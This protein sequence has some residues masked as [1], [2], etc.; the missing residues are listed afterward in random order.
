ML[1]AWADGVLKTIRQIKRDKRVPAMM[2][3][4]NSRVAKPKDAEELRRGRK[5]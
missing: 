1:A 5:R 4:Y 3:S 2:R